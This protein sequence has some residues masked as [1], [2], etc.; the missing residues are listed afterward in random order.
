MKNKI[1]LLDG[2]ALVF[3]AHFAFIK[4]PRINSKGL[5]TSSIFGFTTT[6]LDVIKNQKP[7]H[8]AVV[9]DTE[10]PTHRHEEF[11]AYKANR[12]EAPED[13]STAIPYI[14]KLLDAL[15]IKY[16]TL[17]GFE[18]DDIIGT[19]ATQSAAQANTEVFMMTTDKDFGQLVSDNV[20]IYKPGRGASPAEVLGIKEVC[21]RYGIAHPRQVIDILGLMGDAVD[22]IPGIYGVG[23]KT[24]TQ[25]IQQ[26]GSVEGLLENTAALKG[27][28]RE[29]VEAGKDAAIQ[30]KRLATIVCD[31][32]I[33]W[34][35]QELE[36]KPV[37]R[38]AITELFTELEFRNLSQ[39][40]IAEPVQQGLFDTQEPTLIPS[41]TENTHLKNIHTVAHQYHVANTHQEIEKLID[42]LSNTK[43]FSIDTETT[44]LESMDAELVGM[45]FAVHAHEAWYVPF[46]ANREEAIQ[47]LNMLKPVLQN[48][49]IVK[50]GQNLKYDA[51]VLLNYGIMLSGSW[52]DTM[53]AH[54][55][56]EPEQ[57]H[58]L[59]ALSSVYLGYNPVAI[60][61]LIGAK[62]KAQKSMRDVPLQKIA[63][64]AAEDAD[65]TLQL[66]QH[67]SPELEKNASLER[68]FSKIEMP[69]VP[70][71]LRMERRGIRLDTDAL[72]E[73]SSLLES[74]L[75]IKE[76]EIFESAGQEFNI[77]SP[78]QLG[79]IL[80]EKLQL[81]PKAKKTKTGQY[82]TGEE[83]L[84]RL[85]GKHPLIHQILDYRE[86]IKLK[87]TY[88]DTLPVLVRKSSGHIHTSFNQAVAATGRLSSNNPNLQNIPIRTKLGKEIRKAFVPGGSDRVIVSAD[89]SQVELRIIASLSNET[90]MKDAFQK[91][92]DIHT[93]TASKV[94]GVSLDAVDADMRRKAKV[95]NFG[96]IYG[97]SA[98]G[99]SE[100]L[101]IPR[102]EAKE[103]IGNYFRE[104]PGLQQYMDN[105]IAFARKHGY[106]ET[107]FGRRRYLRDINSA[108]AMTRGFAERN[109]INAPIQGSAADM[110]KLAMIRIDARME[111]EKFRS[112]MVLQVHDELVFD[113]WQ[114]EVEPLMALVREEMCGALPLE[115]PVVVD[116]RSGRNWL[117]A[118]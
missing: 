85:A 90:H 71:L 34:S 117:E 68:V 96:I 1:F 51:G 6:L 21:E 102:Q 113:T 114:D 83:V 36:L 116:I 112:G 99:L 10:D 53:L 94:F 91:G 23:E 118:H 115:V 49:Q 33:N 5:N 3:R 97:I 46:P 81:D 79:E 69:L 59:D 107:V 13:L 2:F 22:N 70:V 105:S 41:P 86:L 27:K 103:I 61:E 17:S 31:A 111:K 80:F 18:A 35:L 62:G 40:I 72:R 26:F 37:N 84:A 82:A 66:Y 7:T 87:N 15:N 44:S 63:E 28:L 100:R 43:A 52:F 25:L 75:K 77:S 55:V 32:P 88:V 108:N 39:R 20:H 92:L 16:Y 110:I 73:F 78:R 93:A 29:K 98:F 95:V 56:I 45:S 24:A 9:F 14:F 19:I 42:I 74:D 47:K 109:A 30:S 48:E 67:L 38:E 104:F 106:V 65:V 57:R 60:D 89:Y 4:N 50:I 64:Y 11:E 54:Y 12:E 101:S 8:I 76:K 58:N